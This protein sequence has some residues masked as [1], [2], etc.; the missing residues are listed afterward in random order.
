MLDI[1]K[2]QRI[3]LVKPNLET[4]P[5]KGKRGRT[6]FVA[7]PNKEPVRVDMY[8][9]KQKKGDCQQKHSIKY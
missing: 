9:G 4:P 1:H 2:N 7:K 8:C 3:F 5:R 6:T